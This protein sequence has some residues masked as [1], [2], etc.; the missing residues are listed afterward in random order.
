MSAITGNTSTH[1][2]E[3]VFIGNESPYIDVLDKHSRLQLIVAD[4]LGRKA[5][6]FFGSAF[7]Y[8]KENNIDLMSAKEYI[9]HPAPVDLI[10]VSGYPKLI[11]PR[12]I[13]HPRIAIINI[14]QSF[15]PA[16]R[17]KHPLNWVI[18]NGEKYAGI[19]IH[20][21]NEKFDD[22]RIICQERVK[23]NKTHTVMDIHWK[24][25]AKGKVLLRRILKMIG[26][27]ELKGFRQDM[28]KASYY[29]PRTPREG[30][31]VWHESAE[32]IINRV[33][34]LVEPYPGAYFYYKRNRIV[35]DSAEVIDI[36]TPGRGIGKPFVSGKHCVVRT[37]KGF[38][39][40]TGIR[41]QNIDL[42]KLV[43]A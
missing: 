20:H 8:A 32:Q 19:T 27:K 37:G 39:K 43:G 7:D 25:V 14:H 15:L 10:V 29:P 31:I 41:N 17:G 23:I 40:I 2:P 30:R 35:I 22:G 12:L 1:G 34:A 11:P 3:S 28:T 33:R 21:I 13:K 24:T 6:E 4:R 42:L 5:R 38:V 18:I 9:S 16:Y 26:R 36:K